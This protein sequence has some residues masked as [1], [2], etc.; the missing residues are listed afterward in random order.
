MK[1]PNRMDDFRM[2]SGV[3][4]PSIDP[5]QSLYRTRRCSRFYPWFR[6]SARSRTRG[7]RLHGGSAPT[8]RSI[9]SAGPMSGYLHSGRVDLGNDS[10]VGIAFRQFE[11]DVAVAA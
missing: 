4:S 1:I 5:R 8:L 11:V 6:S 7:P 2:V 3:G 10:S 9:K